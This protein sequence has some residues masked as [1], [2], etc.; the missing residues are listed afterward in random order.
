[1]KS[2]HVFETIARY[3][4]VPV[5]VV[6]SVSH[7]AGLADAMMEGGLPLAEITFRTPVAAQVIKAMVSHRPEMLLGA[8]TLL[9]AAD[10]QAARAAGAKFAVAPGLNPKTVLYASQ[11]DLPFAPGVCTPSDIEQAMEL[12][13]KI[14][15]FFPAE[16]SGGVS[17]LKAVCAPYSHTGVKFI[18]TGGVTLDNLASYLELDI[19]M[20]VGGTWIAKA[21]DLAAGRWKEIS[22]RCQ[23]AMEI[24][25]RVRG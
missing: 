10:A 11:A 2:D 21:D 6:E 5:I 15:K 1:M 3:G 20:A 25:R 24:I 4:V 18:P 22:E 9:C 23:K 8:G 7:A 13:C 17:M 16:A 12:G 14:L 19:V